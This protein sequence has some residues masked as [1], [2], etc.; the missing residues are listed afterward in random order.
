MPIIGF[1]NSYPLQSDYVKEKYPAT[2]YTFFD[3][4][5][6]FLYDVQVDVLKIN[7]FSD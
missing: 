4:F 1:L 7:I 3:E 6:N 2:F 5:V